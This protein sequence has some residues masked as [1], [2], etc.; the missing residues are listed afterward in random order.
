M[1][2]SHRPA[3]DRLDLR[4]LDVLQRNGALSVAEVASQL[5]L[6]TTTCW[7]RIQQL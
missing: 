4:L 7:R 6:S 3:L 5:K 1:E 2:R